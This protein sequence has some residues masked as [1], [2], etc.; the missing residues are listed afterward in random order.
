MR[1]FIYLLRQLTAVDILLLK[2]FLVIV[3]AAWSAGM[4]YLYQ[5]RTADPRPALIA[6]SS[7]RG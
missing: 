6:N 5:I 7:E 4:I 1:D 3:A 2:I